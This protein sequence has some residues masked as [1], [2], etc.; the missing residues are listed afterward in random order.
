MNDAFN[1]TLAKDARICRSCTNLVT[2]DAK[3]PLCEQSTKPHPKAK[4]KEC[5]CQGCAGGPFPIETLHL[6]TWNDDPYSQTEDGDLY[7]LCPKCRIE[8]G[9]VE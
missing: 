7:F 5:Y 2:T 3:C 4:L 1:N 6:I 9:E 8:Q